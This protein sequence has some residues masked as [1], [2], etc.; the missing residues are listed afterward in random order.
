[1]QRT[2]PR[3]PRALILA[4]AA[5]L[6]ALAP[7]A[8]DAAPVWL[9]A[10]TVD[11]ARTTAGVAPRTDIAMN[12]RGD[13][14]LVFARGDDL[15]DANG[16][17]DT[18]TVFAAY[19]PAGG[20]FGAPQQVS[21]VTTGPVPEVEAGIAAN[22]S[23]IVAF[24][25]KSPSNIQ[26]RVATSNTAGVF[27][28][29]RDVTGAVAGED[30][31]ALQLAANGSGVAALYWQS[32]A[33]KVAYGATASFAGSFS[34][35]TLTTSGAYAGDVEVDQAGNVSWAWE[36]DSSPDRYTVEVRDKPAAG[37][38]G[39]TIILSRN[40]DGAKAE[41]PDLTMAPDG[42]A[43][44][45]YGYREDA[46][47]PALPQRA[48]YNVRSAP[49]GHWDTGTWST[50][51][52]LV[53]APGQLAT[54]YGSQVTMLPDG[55]AVAIYLADTGVFGATRLGGQQFSG[56]QALTDEASS[57]G[58]IASSADGSVVALVQT[59]NDVNAAVRS[60]G[61]TQFGATAT[62]ATFNSTG[63]PG[64]VFATP[65]AMDGTGDATMGVGVARCT[66][67]C[68]KWD[69]SVFTVSL[70]AA[71]P[72]FGAVNIPSSATSGS[73]L[74]FAAPAT[75]V[76]SP[77]S[78]T[79]SFGDGASGTGSTT[80][81]TYAAPGSYAVTVT[82]TD[83]VGHATST[84]VVVQ[85]SAPPASPPPPAPPAPV[86]PRIGSKIVAKWKATRTFTTVS[87][88][89][90]S[91]VPA[92]TTVRVTCTGG[93]CPFKKP[94]SVHFTK[95]TKLFSLTG[96]FSTLVRTPRRHL[97]VAKLKPGAV[98]QVSVTR[99]GY[100]GRF[101]TYRVRAS[102]APTLVA[103]CIAPG[104]VKHLPC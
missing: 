35:M 24:T 4:A 56:H 13:A 90:V 20:T 52:G 76:M 27:A 51:S 28:P 65:L 30:A 6:C 41:G 73:Q 7:A 61:A 100:V 14:V 93:G 64:F 95:L 89:A 86:V 3:A 46:P 37:A 92:G 50:T 87:S 32:G 1:M 101:A 96:R 31:S 22:G 2:I 16:A 57:V 39:A 40:V 47:L 99:P 38:L 12:E 23:A 97:V 44:V 55:T 8:A 29:A 91:A 72:R 81:H 25:S 70:D 43:M 34:P 83:A 26:V 67:A 15:G 17:N 104:S 85:V 82:A 103:G 75:D 36:R 5:V 74:Q 9:P 18:E 80:S 33:A 19:R 62:V 79:W 59:V 10:V 66:A 21:S 71:A 84:S 54:S 42:R 77:I 63:T 102:K 45:V 53:S 49:A 94:Y 78:T 69:S 48:V 98:V 60:P 11:P 68:A 88:L 58:W